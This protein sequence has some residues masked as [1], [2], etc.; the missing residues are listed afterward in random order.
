MLQARVFSSASRSRRSPSR[1]T[2]NA[3][4]RVWRRSCRF[5]GS[6]SSRRSKTETTR[7]SPSS[8]RAISGRPYVVAEFDP[9][10]IADRDVVVADQK[11]PQPDAAHETRGLVEPFGAPPEPRGVIGRGGG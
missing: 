11:H 7:R 2:C 3:W 1:S 9:A 10:E 4:P 5:A 6:L 8:S